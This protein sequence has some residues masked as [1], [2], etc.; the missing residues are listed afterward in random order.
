MIGH[1]PPVSIGI[2]FF[3]A[4]DALRDSIRSVFAQTHEDWELI[5]IDD[6]STDH[7][8]EI[9]RSI[10][11]P[12]V[13][14][15]SDGKNKRLAA[16]LNEIAR[17]AQYDFVARMDADDLMHPTRIERQLRILCDNPDLDMISTG[18]YSLDNHNKPLGTR[19]VSS[20]H[21]ITPK[22]LLDGNCGILNA[23]VIAKRDWFLRNP[24]K[25]TLARAQDANLWLQAYSRDDLAVEIMSEP[26]YF[27]REDDNVNLSRILGAYKIMRHSIIADAKQRYRKR[28]RIN[29]YVKNLMKSA[30]VWTLARTSGLE[31]LRKRRITKE[32]SQG[33]RKEITQVIEAIQRT[34]LPMGKSGP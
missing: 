20:Q 28:D 27:Y 13:R 29:A 5:L 30:M 31:L 6:G 7:S 10:D 14:V 2:P 11:D 26:L 9:A 4:S 3:N 21:V 12:R 24:F 16:R 23:A 18:V 19:C 33:K 34:E 32:I 8:L 15:F 22:A 25:E 17:L 1:L